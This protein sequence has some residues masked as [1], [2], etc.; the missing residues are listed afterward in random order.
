MNYICARALLHY[1]TYYFSIAYVCACYWPLFLI[2]FLNFVRA[3]LHCALNQGA[4][5]L[6]HLFGFYDV[7]FVVTVITPAAI[8]SSSRSVSIFSVQSSLSSAYACIIC[9]N[10]SVNACVDVCCFHFFALC[11]IHVGTRLRAICMIVCFYLFLL[12]LQV[13]YSW[14]GQPAVLPEAPR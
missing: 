3:S 13:Q 14:G 2:A 12:R 4:R 11:Y 9:W 1:V 7:R 6:A 8:A 10:A 5:C